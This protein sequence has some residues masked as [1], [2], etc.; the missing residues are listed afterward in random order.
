MTWNETLKMQ[1]DAKT[2]IHFTNS[3]KCI[4]AFKSIIKVGKNV[5]NN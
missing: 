2:T 3:W 1:N 4:K 5:K